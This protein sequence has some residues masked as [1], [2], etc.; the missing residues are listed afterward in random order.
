M[1]TRDKSPAF[2]LEYILSI[3]PGP[4]KTMNP[5]GFVIIKI[6]Y[7]AL[8]I[9][10]F[11]FLISLTA[12]YVNNRV[13]ERQVFEASM[14]IEEYAVAGFDVNDSAL[15]FGTVGKGGTSTRRIRIENKHSFPIIVFIQADGNIKTFLNYEEYIRIDKGMAESIAVS[16][17][18]PFD[19]SEGFYSGSVEFLIKSA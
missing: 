1:N 8:G 2:K 19:A 12:Y 17:S 16:A 18:A 14:T 4:H 11:A 5:K 3:S 6:F 9:S 7:F 15:T 13:I 10:V